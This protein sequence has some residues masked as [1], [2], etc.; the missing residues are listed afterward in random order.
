MW[1]DELPCPPTID[2]DAVKEM[3]R[4]D[5]KSEGCIISMN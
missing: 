4:E 1:E 2:A 3:C 5:Q